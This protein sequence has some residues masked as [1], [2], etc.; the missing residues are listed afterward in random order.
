MLSQMGGSHAVTTS[1][2]RTCHMELLRQQWQ[3]RLCLCAWR[4]TQDADLLG[5]PAALVKAEEL[6]QHRH[7][8]VGQRPQRHRQGAQRGKPQAG[9]VVGAWS[10]KR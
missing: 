4:E 7:K 10:H 9:T 2:N 6:G 3:E 8:V 5:S 1:C